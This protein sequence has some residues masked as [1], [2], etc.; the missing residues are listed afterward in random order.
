MMIVTSLSVGLITSQYSSGTRKALT[1]QST[2][3]MRAIVGDGRRLM[4]QQFALL[5]S[6]VEIE[7]FMAEDSG[8]TDFPY[9][10]IPSY[11]DH[12]DYLARPI[13]TD[14]RYAN[15]SSTVSFAH[16]S[17]HVPTR[18]PGDQPSFSVALNTS[19]D[20][21]AS[22]DPV[23]RNSWNAGKQF[24]SL[25]H[26]LETTGV[27]REFPGVAQANF[28]S[29]LN[30][31]PRNEDWYIEAKANIQGA[32]SSEPAQSVFSELYFDPYV[33]ENMITIARGYTTITSSVTATPSP[34]PI[35]AR[36]LLLLSPVADL[37]HGT[38]GAV[39]A[40]QSSTSFSGAAGGDIVVAEVQRA[41][42]AIRYLDSRTL[43]L[44]TEGGTIVADSASTATSGTAN[45]V[46]YTSLR[47]PTISASTFSTLTAGAAAAGTSGTPYLLDATG[48]YFASQPMAAGGGSDYVLVSIVNKDT[49]LASLNSVLSDIDAV[50][51]Q[52]IV[53]IVRV[54]P[55]PQPVSLCVSVWVR[56][57]D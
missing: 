10:R 18:S 41:T 13:T 54:T 47:N 27:F 23:M 28:A 44:E 21:S 25:Y 1:D 12:K 33:N 49:V 53:T 26:G 43:L 6:L 14:R 22:L 45:I 15:G 52:Y 39:F 31:D 5:K 37:R 17:Y 7:A 9:G 34:V 16:S 56:C 11:Y 46:T 2:T 57:G 38:W 4:D 19:I 40:V 24:I 3:H 55:P 32:S 36:L 50:L 48:Y 35:P 42:S 51:Q 29:V 8:R 20:R 30:Y